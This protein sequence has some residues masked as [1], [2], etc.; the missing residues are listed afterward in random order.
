[1]RCIAVINQKGG[2]GKTTLSVNLGHALA[3]AGY[4]VTVIDMDP[5]GHVATSLG[6]FRPP[7]KGMDDVLLNGADLESHV[8]STREGLRLIPA[9]R[10]LEKVEQLD[11]GASRARLL[12]EALQR[13]VS[14]QDYL[15]IDCPPAF[16]LLMSNV[17]MAVDE[18]LVPA[19]GDY[20]GLNG[21]AQLIKTI[22]RFEPF[23]RRSLPVW[24]AMSRF[25]PRRRLSREVLDKVNQYFPGRVLATHI[26]EMVALAECP[27]V[28]RTIFEY[29]P[30]SESAKAFVS[31]ARDLV[32]GRTM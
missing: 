15:L 20:L 14:E 2:V 11:G 17:I 24:V 19:T 3:L 5:Q 12:Q 13:G 31:L 6:I 28:G 25:Q 16:G 10:H 22:R 30:G 29:R 7:E 9:G 23:R 18:A 21:M 26:K 8:I 1:M 32:E 27:G 4:R